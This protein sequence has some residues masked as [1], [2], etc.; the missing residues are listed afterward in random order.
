M[1]TAEKTY[2]EDCEPDIQVDQII[3][4]DS[5]NNTHDLPEKDPETR[6]DDDD[7]VKASRP[8]RRFRRQKRRSRYMTQDLIREKSPEALGIPISDNNKSVDNEKSVG[9]DSE[10]TSN[11]KSLPSDLEP[12]PVQII[13]GK[14]IV[15]CNLCKKQM[16]ESR[17]A[18]HIR[19][20]HNQIDEDKNA[21]STKKKE[22]KCEHC[23]KE[24]ATK[25]TYEQHMKTH[26][27]GRPK[28]PECGSTFASPFSMFRHRAKAHNIDHDYTTYDCKECDGKFFSPSEL[29][30]HKQRHSTVKEHICPKCSKKFTVKGNLTMHMRTHDQRKLFSCDICDTSFSHP[31]SLTSHRRIHTN[32]FPYVCN[33]CGKS[34][35]SKH[36]LTSH[37]FVHTDDRP[38]ACTECSK[39]FR[40]RTAFKMH[41]DQHKGI[42]RFTCMYCERK[43]QC[44]ANKLK[45]ERRHIG[46]KKH[47][48]DQC[49]K[50]FIE[51]QELRNHLKVHEKMNRDISTSDQ[52]AAKKSTSKKAQDETPCV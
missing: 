14:R 22:F 50:A 13:N 37:Q 8:V 10:L 39:T 12:P 3:T 46:E 1:A 20:M 7:G 2:I 44:H 30:L 34:Y 9:K 11:Q 17:L 49:E 26:K 4:D 43:F 18:N 52:I 19:L 29:S 21:T 47:K 5:K 28:C 33:E 42:K 35:R 24:Y 51:K 23:G 36:Q 25:Y 15:F 31:F 41:Q 32:E 48:C 45:H 6:S 27:E 38:F 40:S 16:P